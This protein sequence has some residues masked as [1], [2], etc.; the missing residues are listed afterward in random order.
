MIRV[1]LI[2]KKKMILMGSLD[3]NK[4]IIFNFLLLMRKLKNIYLDL[5]DC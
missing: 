5:N 1:S 4:E 2:K 3:F